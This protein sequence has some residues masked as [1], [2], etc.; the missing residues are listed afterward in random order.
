MFV[1]IKSRKTAANARIIL[2]ALHKAYPLKIS[3]LL[4]DGGKEFTDRLFGSRAVMP[5][6]RTNWTGC[7]RNWGLSTDLLPSRASLGPMG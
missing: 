3:K 4:T 7:V 5:R 2:G 6:G 1:Q